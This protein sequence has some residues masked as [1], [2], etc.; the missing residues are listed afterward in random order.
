[1][2]GRSRRLALAIGPIV[3]IA[4]THAPAPARAADPPTRSIAPTPAITA[5]PLNT[6][7]INGFIPRVV[8]GLTSEQ[9]PNDLTYEAHPSSSPSGTQYPA[10]G[11]PKYFVATFD[12]GAQSHI[13]SY[14]SASELLI[15]GPP[16]REGTYQSE[17]V[18]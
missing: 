18:G 1:M 7:P 3:A 2:L 11:G 14:D 15:Q 8:F 12:T 6:P 5:L 17:I 16:S 13:I 4:A 10:S 9:A